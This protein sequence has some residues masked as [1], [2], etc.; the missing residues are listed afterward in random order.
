MLSPL[1][2][3]HRFYALAAPP[4]ISE[5][6]SALRDCTDRAAF[7]SLVRELLPEKAKEI[8]ETPMPLDL[9]LEAF[10]NAFSDRY[11]PI[12]MANLRWAES[13]GECLR[14][15]VPAPM[16]I[17]GEAYS[18]GFIEG[19]SPMAALCRSPLEEMYL[20]DGE[21][22]EG[23]PIDP[24]RTGYLSQLAGL[25]GPELASRVPLDGIEID[26]L[27]TRL[28][29]TR[30]APVVTVAEMLFGESNWIWFNLDE[31]AL[32]EGEYYEMGEDGFRWD[33]KSIEALSADWGQ[34]KVEW[35]ALWSLIAWLEQDARNVAE[36]VMAALGPEPVQVR[37]N[38]PLIEVFSAERSEDNGPNS[39]TR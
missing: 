21:Y 15:A 14:L 19:L 12:W 8:I 13:L 39:P 35:D 26:V 37:A 29:G 24:E 4:S 9:Q 38:T 22:E 36:M 16:G 20:M 31:Q 10:A 2:L 7:R 3:A 11:F 32:D 6:V 25:V 27:R 1:A 18:Q 5:L 28:R 30:F 17:S 33:M 34:A 23:R